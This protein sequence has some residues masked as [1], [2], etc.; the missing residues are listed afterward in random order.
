VLIKAVLTALPT[1]FMSL[2][3]VPN[4]V[5][6]FIETKTRKFFWGGVDEESGS[7]LLPWEAFSSSTDKGEL[8]IGNI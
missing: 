5:A 6:Q 1:F 3:K 8:G 4:S 7:N 2:F